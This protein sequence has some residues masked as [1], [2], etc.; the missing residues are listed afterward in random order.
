M[1]RRWT[2]T[3]KALALA[4]LLLTGWGANAL[5]ETGPRIELDHRDHH[6]GKVTQGKVV[7][8]QF[9]FKNVGD[10]D[11]VIDDVS[12]PCGCTAVLPDKSTLKPGESSY[13]E[14]NYDSSARSG[15]VT[16]VITL[17]SNDAV[18]PELTLE[19]TATVDSS[20]HSAFEAGIDLFG[21]KCGKCHALPN[22]GKMDQ[23]LYETACWFCH[24]KQ[25]QGNTATALGA[26]PPAS[27]AFLRHVITDGLPGT[28]MP[29]FG[30]GKGGPLDD[31]QIESLIQILYTDPPEPPALEAEPD[32][33]TPAFKTPDAPFFQ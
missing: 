8:H 32:D 3:L 28:E 5:A 15:E 25:R 33:A 9:P 10:A 21:P 1:S 29:G 4:C 23:E 31:R 27:E 30:H 11:L 2:S 12:T 26:Y 24:G 6:F 13:I 22:A 18:E 14:V 16:R 19:V 7:I 17:L 20:M